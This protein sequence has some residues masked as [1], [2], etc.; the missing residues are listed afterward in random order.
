MCQSPGGSPEE[1]ASVPTK[2]KIP[3]EV[4]STHHHASCRE[5]QRIRNLNEYL[6]SVQ[7]A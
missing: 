6:V 1:E 2:F 3:E 7:A 4:M 5:L